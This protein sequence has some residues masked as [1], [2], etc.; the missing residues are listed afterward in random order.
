MNLPN[1]LTIARLLMVPVFVVMAMIDTWWGYG[2]AAII[3][4]AAAIT[5]FLD[6]RIARA[7]NLVTNFGK[8][9]DPLADKVLV[10]SA[11]VMMMEIS[12]LHVPGW[13][14]VVILA[15]EFLVTGARSVATA[16]G[17]VLAAN[18]WGKTKAMLQMLYIGIFLSL[19]AIVVALDA[20]QP[21]AF[22]DAAQW[23]HSASYYVVLVVTLITVYSGFQFAKSNWSVL[24]LGPNE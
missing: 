18:I 9:M 22:P 15:R 6:G 13:A 7:R 8:L 19:T 16:E 14:V 24:K 1:R 4:T 17:L 11:F 20:F 23:L 12:W 10:A 21:D 2:L 5:D 3:F